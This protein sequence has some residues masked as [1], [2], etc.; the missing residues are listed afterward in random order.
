MLDPLPWLPEESCL[1]V[2]V[3]RWGRAEMVGVG[4][5]EDEDDEELDDDLDDLEDD[6]DDE[7]H[8]ELLVPDSSQLAVLD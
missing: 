4:D 2:E 5:R 6:E 1:A 8:A 7:C 3:A